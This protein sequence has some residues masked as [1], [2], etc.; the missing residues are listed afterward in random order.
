MIEGG[1]LYDFYYVS[2][3][4]YL[5]EDLVRYYSAQLFLSIEYLHKRNILHRDLKLENVMI[6]NKTGNLKLIDFGFA[7]QKRKAKSFWFDL[8]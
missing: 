7:I 6:D 3:P 2:S 1:S 8:N 5:S 4:K